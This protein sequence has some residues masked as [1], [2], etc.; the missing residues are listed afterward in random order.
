M[1][2]P[3]AL[4]A[5]GAVWVATIDPGRKASVAAAVATLHDDG[6]VGWA[7]A[8][9]AGGGLLDLTHLAP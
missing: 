8:Y 3:V 2:I 1:P 7:E 9:E 4:P 5:F 6:A